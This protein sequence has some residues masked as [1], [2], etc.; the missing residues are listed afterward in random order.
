MSTSKTAAP[1]SHKVTLAKAHTHAGQDY[2]A[3]DQ[4]EVDTATAQWLQTQGVTAPAPA[5]DTAKA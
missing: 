1:A 3:G 4:I 2:Q 5:A